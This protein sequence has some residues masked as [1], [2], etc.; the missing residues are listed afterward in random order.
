M[1]VATGFS[2]HGFGMGPGA[3]VVVSELVLDGQ[4]SVDIHPMR[5]GRFAE[6]QP[7]PDP[8]AV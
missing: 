7:N 4:A 8:E 6:G 3:G 1:L 2:G 5:L